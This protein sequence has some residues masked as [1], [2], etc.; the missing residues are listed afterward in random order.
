[1]ETPQH[2]IVWATLTPE[3]EALLLQYIP[4]V[5]PKQ[6]HSHV[7][8]AFKITAQE[9]EAKYPGILNTYHFI[10]VSSWATDGTRI[11]AVPV[12][13]SESGLVSSNEHP[14]ITLSAIEGAK[15]VESNAML[16][17]P[18]QLHTLDVIL[19]LPVLVEFSPF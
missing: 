4:R 18:A 6:F 7:T 19:E 13:L 11:Q 9:F 10:R 3:S 5:F 2:G 8:L 15:P 12:D 1:M 17:H 14:H 16:L